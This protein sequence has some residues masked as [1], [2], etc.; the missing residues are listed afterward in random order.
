MK[1]FFVSLAV[2]IMLASMASA[3][4]VAPGWTPA[5]CWDTTGKL[6]VDGEF[7]IGIDP[8]QISASDFLKDLNASNSEI[9]FSEYSGEMPMG[10]QLYL[11]IQ[12]SSNDPTMG[13]SQLIADA[14]AAIQGMLNLN[15]VLNASCNSIAT[16]GGAG[17]ASN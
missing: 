14:D 17:T 11:F 3:A 2:S 6:V 12:A 13:R 15:G 9:S 1:S 10:S 5:Q 4:Q 8:A 7:I 16:I